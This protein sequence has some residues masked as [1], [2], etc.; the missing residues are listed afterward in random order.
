MKQGGFVMMPDHL[1]TPDTPLAN[2]RYYLK[3]IREMRF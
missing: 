3:R 1:I 2:Y